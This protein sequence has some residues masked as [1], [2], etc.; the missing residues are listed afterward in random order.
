MNQVNDLDTI[1][2]EKEEN[3]CKEIKSLS[4]LALEL[5]ALASCGP[6]DYSF[7]RDFKFNVNSKYDIHY[8]SEKSK[9]NYENKKANL[10]Q[11]NHP[12]TTTYQRECM[13][14]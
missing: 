10:I 14:Q 8:E 4:V 2:E 7:F 9:L 3:M 12:T 11:K 13:Y 1:T 5:L 6:Y